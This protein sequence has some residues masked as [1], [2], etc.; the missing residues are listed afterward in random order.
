MMRGPLSRALALSLLG[1]L[2]LLLTWPYTTPPAA[3]RP[4]M[5]VMLLDGRGAAVGSPAATSRT[6][7]PAPVA[8]AAPPAPREPA[9]S[10]LPAPAQRTGQAEPRRESPESPAGQQ[11]EAAALQ[12]GRDPG[13]DRTQGP[14]RSQENAGEAGGSTTRPEGALRPGEAVD[15]EALQAYRFALAQQARLFR[16]YPA[17]ARERGWEGR[18][19]IGISWTRGTDAPRIRLLEGSGHALLDEQALAMMTQ[20]LQRT[21]MPDGLRG[22]SFELVMPVEFSLE[23]P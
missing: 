23:H 16:R 5:Q 12:P 22:R 17:L 6:P 8:E 15:A 13:V 21:P 14:A 10:P 3:H 18:A 7:R 11:P 9:A 4:G 19:R 2:L 1:H 20:A